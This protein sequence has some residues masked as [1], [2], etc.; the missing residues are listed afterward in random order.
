MPRPSRV[1]IEFHPLVP[2]RWADFEKL[3]GPRGACAGCWCMWWRL[4]RSDWNKGR[5]DGNRKAMRELV[6]SGD[7]P[8][9]LAYADGVPVG[10]CSVAPREEF[11]TLERSRTLKRID[12]E[13]V[14]SVVCFFIAR[15]FRR[16]GLTVGL[17][18]SAV[19][20]AREKGARI[21]EG[22][23]VAP[24]KGTMPDAFA[25]T[26]LVSAFEA[27]G[28]VEAARRSPTRPIMRRAVRGRRGK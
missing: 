27:A 16:K 9:I 18:K 26:G 8:G 1:K 23:P 12:E 10:W 20:F 25:Y 4:R 7:S 21:V 11:A 3:F 22:Y 19:A 14:W 2:E 5:G 24:R 15:P 17:L 13:P 6:R 28:F